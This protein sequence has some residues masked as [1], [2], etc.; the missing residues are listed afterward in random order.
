MKIKRSVNEIVDDIVRSKGD[1]GVAW[2]CVLEAM[3]LGGGCGLYRVSG[4]QLMFD[5]DDVVV[6]IRGM[7]KST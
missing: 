2:V 6:P 7:D 3:S 4:G 5:E 1:P